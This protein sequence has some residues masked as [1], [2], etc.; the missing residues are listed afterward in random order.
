MW[1]HNLHV[2]TP[3]QCEYI[4]YIPLCNVCVYHLSCAWIYT[5]LQTVTAPVCFITPIQR[6][7]DSSFAVGL[8][9]YLGLLDKVQIFTQASNNVK[10]DSLA[11]YLK[12]HLNSVLKKNHFC[13]LTLN[14]II[15]HHAC[16]LSSLFSDGE[17]WVSNRNLAFT[18]TGHIHAHKRYHAKIC[19]HT[20]VAVNNKCIN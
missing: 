11:L 9:F 17:K 8:I 12:M 3:V 7:M 6:H 4:T 13:Y 18:V 20:P 16:Y 19:F 15:S 10:S 1:I 14:K 5:P 2:Y